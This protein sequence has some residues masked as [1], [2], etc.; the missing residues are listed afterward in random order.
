MANKKSLFY[1]NYKIEWKNIEKTTTN[2][3]YTLN[4]ITEISFKNIKIS[5]IIKY[6][7]KSGWSFAEQK[8]DIAQ[9]TPKK[10]YNII[11]GIT[12]DSHRHKLLINNK[13]STNIIHLPITSALEN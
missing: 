6:D 8:L 9:L 11:Y 5:F 13:H 4:F 3:L 10:E 1:I 7:S 12:E 2:F